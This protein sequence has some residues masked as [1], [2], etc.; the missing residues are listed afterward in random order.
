M[1]HPER[2]LYPY[3][4]AWYHPERGQDEISPW[5]EIFTDAYKWLSK[6]F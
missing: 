2:S 3:N 4:W 5:I 1:P 6:L